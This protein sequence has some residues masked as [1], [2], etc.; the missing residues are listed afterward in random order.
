MGTFFTDTMTGLRQAV[1]IEKRIIQT[2][3]VSNMPADT[4]RVIG[5][6]SKLR[7]GSLERGSLIF[8]S[9]FFKVIATGCCV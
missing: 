4:Y 7:E 8:L 3:K 5:A 1:D 9:I 6:V 2:E